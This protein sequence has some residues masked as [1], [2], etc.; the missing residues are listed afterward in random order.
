MFVLGKSGSGKSTLLNL[1]GGL[2]NI[3]SGSITVDGNNLSKF[4]EKAFCNYRNTHI[5]F[6][7]QDYHLIDELT[8]YDN[9]ALSL[10]L[11]RMKDKEAV[12][13]ALA[14]VDLAGYEDRYPTELSGGEQQRVAIARA[15]VKKPRII[16]ADEPT[17][18]LD[19]NTATAIV[20]LLKELSKECLI[21][22]VS[23]NI[24]DANNYADR[25]IEL[26]KGEIISD[27]S[28]NPEFLDE[29][30]LSDGKLIYPQGLALSDNDIDF[31][32]NN[33]NKRFIKKTDKFIPTPALKKEAKKVK[34]ENK[35]LSFGKKLHLSGKFLKSKTF[36]ISASAVMVAIIMV[37]MAMAQTIISFDGSAMIANE[38]A[39]QQQ[40]TLLLNKILDAETQALVNGNH[41]VKIDD[42]DI[43]SFYNSGYKG[44]IYPVYNLTVPIA[45]RRNTVGQASSH[46]TRPDFIEETI[47][48]IIVDEQFLIN[49]FG[50][51]TYLAQARELHPSGIIITD[52]VADSIMAY[53]TNID[54]Y[55][56]I[57][58]NYYYKR[59][60]WSVPQVYIN[61]IIDTGYK[62]KY[63]KTLDVLKN[64]TEADLAD[65][66]KNEEF[67][68]FANEIYTS[69]GLSYTF[70][71]DIFNDY[72][73]SFAGDQKPKLWPYNLVINDLLDFPGLENG[74]G[75]I[76]CS[77]ALQGN[78]IQIS[79]EAYNE[80]FGTKYT[81]NTIDS[82]VPHTIK[83]S[84]F[85][86]YDYTQENPLFEE[87]ILLTGLNTRGGSLYNTIVVSEELYD[88][89]KENH[90]FAYSLYF[91]GTEGIGSVLDS[92]E[93]LQYEPQNYVVEGIHTMTKAVD[94]FVPIFELVAIF[95]CLGVVFILV[96]F[97]SKMIRDKMHEIGILKAL[98]TKNGAIIIVFGLQVFLV[99]LL[100]AGLS[101]VG[102]YYFIDFANDVLFQSM[103]QLVPNQV[104]LD[105]DFFVFMPK[106][107]IINCLLVFALS[108]ISLITP[109]LKIKAIK[110]VKIIKAKE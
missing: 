54:N 63:A 51:L 73:I 17:G 32:N 82:F 105:L 65:Y 87:D 36:A 75:Y 12:S 62:E 104:V 69:L 92:A 31:I 6:I 11:R 74:T 64:I 70:N 56:E 57:I 14:K 67:L 79:Y 53:Y 66:A 78:E 35:G 108:A 80:L 102:Y 19:T 30:S 96:N 93:N 103:Q 71:K 46:F 91:D 7:F 39:K 89:F 47:G 28:R 10:N 24:N 9:I 52:Y 86:R 3:T 38:M 42:N 109:M 41:R 29:M 76:I 43:A 8:V 15:I 44:Q 107:A 83:L 18:N 72:D 59:L 23:H 99:A 48:T 81:A 88:I 5:G 98:G 95:L 37:I 45:H 60:G 2:D 90:F 58:G 94:V 106:V 27:K 84:Q 50:K 100:T 68:Q 34:I 97:A 77:D 55:N 20:T 4:C 85:M 26:R 13:K 40:N 101:T 25:I 33:L 110:P 61:G 1:I 16:L 49:K 21:L 22:I